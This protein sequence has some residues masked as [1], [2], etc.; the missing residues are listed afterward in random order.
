MGRGPE[1][2][3]TTNE[4]RHLTPTALTKV[5]CA[6]TVTVSYRVDASG[7]AIHINGGE[8]GV[9]A[10]IESRRLATMSKGKLVLLLLAMIGVLAACGDDATPT[11]TATSTADVPTPTA[12]L[13]P[14]P[15]RRRHRRVNGR[16]T[17]GG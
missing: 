14:I 17:V 12:T 16:S 1:L 13:T 3:M 4:A 9:F 8:L 7:T 11:P 15:R 5:A 6:R 2:V 10:G